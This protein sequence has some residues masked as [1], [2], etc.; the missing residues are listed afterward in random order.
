MN[1]AFKS[2]GATMA[3]MIGFLFGMAPGAMAAGPRYDYSGVFEVAFLTI[4]GLIAMAQIIPELFELMRKRAE[5]ERE[6]ELGA[7]AQRRPHHRVA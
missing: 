6:A 1:K 5:E 3:L 4:C 7:A 2:I